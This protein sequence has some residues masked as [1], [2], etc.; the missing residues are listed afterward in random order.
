MGNGRSWERISVGSRVCEVRFQFSPVGFGCV[1][2]SDGAFLEDRSKWFSSWFLE[3]A[4]LTRSR[5]ARS[6]HALGRTD[7]VDA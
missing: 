5:D 2:T 4:G 7:P 6:Y 1:G 3:K